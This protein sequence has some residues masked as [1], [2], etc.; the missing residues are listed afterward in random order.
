MTKLYERVF[1]NWKK[2]NPDK[3]HDEIKY[4]HKVATGK[5]E[6][7]PGS[8]GVRP[9]WVR[10]RLKELKKKKK[11]KDAFKA[12]KEVEFQPHH[13]KK[14]G[15]FGPTGDARQTWRHIISR[16][17]FNQGDHENFKH[18]NTPY[19]INTAVKQLF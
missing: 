9:K 5:A 15:W 17:Y 18:V 13:I 8:V 1:I 11:W 3:E 12:A 4:Q 16:K 19:K 14:V 7:A 2:P 6:P 10:K